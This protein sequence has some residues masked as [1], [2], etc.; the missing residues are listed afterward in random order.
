MT[1]QGH[2]VMY[3][4]TKNWGF[5][6]EKDGA[7]WFFHLDNCWPGYSP[8]LEDEV[9]FKIAPPISVG[10]RNQA[11]DVRPIGSPI[12]GLPDW[13]DSSQIAEME[14]KGGGAL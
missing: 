14:G 11:A 7:E 2:V 10:K 6:K 5:V 1:H 3:H 12:S 4:P 13:M 9:E 8:K